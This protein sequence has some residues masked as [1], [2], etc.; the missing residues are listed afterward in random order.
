MNTEI[1]NK[2][3]ESMKNTLKT[4]SERIEGLEKQWELLKD[5]L[6]QLEGFYQ[7]MSDTVELDVIHEIQ[8][9]IYKMET[10]EYYK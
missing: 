2:V 1:K 5:E 9:L 7:R 3:I 10:G 6:Q 4:Q 8:S